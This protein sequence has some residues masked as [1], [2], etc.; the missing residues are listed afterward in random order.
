MFKV[1][2][3]C[4]QTKT[5]ADFKVF[6][7]EL[8]AMLNDGWACATITHT[9]Q[10]AVATCIKDF[11]DDHNVVAEDSAAFPPQKSNLM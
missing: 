1:H 2:T 10:L 3:I 11:P 5:P 7:T 6:D 8:A 4:R 9:N